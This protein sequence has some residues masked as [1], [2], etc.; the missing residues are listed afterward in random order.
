[1]TKFPYGKLNDGDEGE[2]QL[3]VNNERG[4]VV[5]AFPKPIV[6]IGLTG[7]ETMQLAQILIRHAKAA[8]ITKPFTMEL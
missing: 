5:I 6:W 1:M 2:T 8:G 7:D 4:C 3:V